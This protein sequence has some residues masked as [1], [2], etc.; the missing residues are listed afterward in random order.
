MLLFIGLE[1]VSIPTYILLSLKRTDA[2]GQEASLKYFF[3]SLIASALFL[4]S[5]TCLYG[6]GGST[7]LLAIG[8]QIQS[9]GSI[10]SPTIDGSTVVGIITVSMATV[11]LP[12]MLGTALAGAAFQMAA[13]PMH[14]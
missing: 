4:Y 5:V 10:A 7:S 2:A 11:L 6:L 8:N 3:L 13:V 1:L 9:L 14:F 12:V